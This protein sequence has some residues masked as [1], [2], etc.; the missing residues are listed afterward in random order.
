MH[1]HTIDAIMQ[2]R[3]MAAQTLTQQFLDAV[4]ALDQ[5]VYLCQFLAGERLPALREGCLLFLVVEEELDF[6]QGKAQ[7]LSHL[8]E[9]QPLKD[10][11]IVAALTTHPTW[12]WQ[13]IDLF[14]IADSGGA[15]ACLARN[16]TNRQFF[17]EFSAG[18]GLTSSQLEYLYCHC[19]L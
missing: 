12:R 1:Q 5:Q 8:N 17:H 7:L 14:I 6:C 19:R 13:K 4:G 18:L 2:I 10:R 11:R 9:C 16:L 3:A 15:Q